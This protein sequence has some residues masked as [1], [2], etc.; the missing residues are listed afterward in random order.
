[1]RALYIFNREFDWRFEKLE[2]GAARHFA[3]YSKR[4]KNRSI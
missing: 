4:S 3:P 2:F 1:M